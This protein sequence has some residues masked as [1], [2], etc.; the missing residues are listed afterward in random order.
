MF[1]VLQYTQTTDYY[2]LNAPLSSLLSQQDSEPRYV[3]VKPEY[4]SY[5]S[6]KVGQTKFTN[7]PCFTA[8]ETYWFKA[9]V[10]FGKAAK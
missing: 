2:G 1:S 7:Y 5:E 3:V 9:S 10:S 8:L 6:I 4:S